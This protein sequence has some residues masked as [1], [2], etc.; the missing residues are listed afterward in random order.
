MRINQTLL[1]LLFVSINLLTGQ[2]SLSEIGLKNGNYAVGFSH[3]K[4]YD[5][6]RTYQRIA[7]WDT[8]STARPILTSIWYPAIKTSPPLEPLSVLNY[9][10]ILKVEEEWEYLPNEHILNWFY[11]ANTTENQKHLSEQ[12]TAFSELRAVKGKFPVV[13]YAPSYQAVS[14][15]NFRLCEYLASHGYVVIAST[16]RGA[17]NRFFE[18]GTA[19]DMETQARD[20]EFLIQEVRKMEIANMDQLGLIGFSFGGLSNMVVQMRN[21]NIKAVMSLDGTERYRYELLEKSPFFDFKKIDV[22]YLHIAQKEIPEEVI[23]KD[24]INPELNYKFQLYDSLQNS[25]AYKMKFNALSHSYFSTLGVLFQ[26]RDI[27]QDK[28]DSEIMESY[29]WVS[30]YVLNFFNGHLKGSVDALQF[31]E[32]E[33]Q[34]NGLKSDLVQKESKKPK[35]ANFDFRVFHELVREDDYQN[36]FERYIEFRK[37]HP[38]LEIPEGALNNLGLQLVFNPKTAEKGIKVF[39]FATRLYPESSNLYDSMGEGYFFMG[40]NEKAISSFET[41]LRLDSSNQNAKNRLIQLK[42]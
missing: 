36:I 6:S 29:K 27:R 5:S 13:V 28:S 37:E 15:E 38:E 18:G 30:E 21:A 3:Y 41:S 35:T 4:T 19:K 17:D 2:T 1:V 14:I 16:S 25:T 12:T 8:K 42:N 24:N 11:Y 39:E 40:N 22:P 31:L 20:V 26:T 10:E 33:P 32:N 23:K 7:D 34:E 9:M